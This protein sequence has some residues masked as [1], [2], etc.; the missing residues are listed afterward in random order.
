MGIFSGKKQKDKLVLIFDIG[1]ASVGGALVST[2]SLQ[3]PKIIFAT[4]ESIPITD[5]T[6]FED[7]L[8]NT[9]KALA[10]VSSRIADARLGSVGSVFCVLS[11]AWYISQ[12]RVV[13]L[14]KSIPFIFNSKLADELIA[15]EVAL[16][17]EEHLNKFSETNHNLRPIEL[18][19]IKTT[20]NGYETTDPLGQSANE[21]IM[22]I[23]ISLSEDRVLRLFE[24]SIG[25]Y[26]HS[27]NIKFA[28]FVMTSFLAVRDMYPHQDDFLLI[29]IAGEVTDITMIKKNTLRESVS[30][31]LG[32]NFALRSV[33]RALLVSLKEAETLFSLYKDGHAS[34]VVK[35]KIMKA[36]RNVEIEWLKNFQS[37]VA[38]LSNDISIPAT[39]FLATD[40]RFSLFFTEIIKSE[41]F[42]QYTLTN[43]K[44]QIMFLDTKSLHGAALFED[45]VV[46]DPFLIINA[47]YI[48]RFLN[49]I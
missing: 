46:R 22:N 20:L 40:A 27:L 5:K 23:F 13:K 12:T 14:E 33:S 38:N 6:N 21:V 1:S 32:Y 42:N 11:S 26:F 34:E 36:L 18:K 37:S 24:E 29:D 48:N 8:S 44:F 35:N 45:E 15:K 4:R 41:Q 43:S 30:Y 49:K 19:N 28:S 39:I 31:P 9:N 3:V 47:I 17:E 25:Q 7:L 2:S 16:F 10:V